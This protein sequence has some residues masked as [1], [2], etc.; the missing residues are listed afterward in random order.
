MAALAPMLTLLS[1]LSA[2]CE[3]PKKTAETMAFFKVQHE[4]MRQAEDFTLCLDDDVPNFSRFEP[5]TCLAKDGV[6]GDFIVEKTP[7]HVV[8]PN[9]HVDIGARAALLV[10]PSHAIT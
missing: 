7:L 2:G 9:A 4:L 6:A 3:P 5:G 8:F 10:V 1:S